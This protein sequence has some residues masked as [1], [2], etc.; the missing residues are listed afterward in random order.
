MNVPAPNATLSVA[1]IL[2]EG[3]KRHGELPAITLGSVST[4]YSELWDQTRAYAGALRAAGVQEGS[5]IAILIPNVTD[6]ARVYQH[7]DQSQEER[8]EQTAQSQTV[9]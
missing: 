6:F 8:K 7:G 4:S 5:R 2:A 9:P 1:A 3:A